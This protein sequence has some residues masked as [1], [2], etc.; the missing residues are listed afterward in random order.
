MKCFLNIFTRLLI[1]FI[2]SSCGKAEHKNGIWRATVKTESGVEVPFNFILSGSAGKKQLYIINGDERFKVNV[3][4]KDNDSL[5][6]QIPMFDC[7]IKAKIGNGT[8]TGQ[9]IKHLAAKDIIMEFNAKQ[10]VS[11]RFLKTPVKPKYNSTGRWSAPF[12]NQEGKTNILIG[13]FKQ[14]ANRLTGTFLSTTGDYRFLEGTISDDKLFLSSFN[15]SDIYLFTATLKSDSTIADGKFYSGYS[16]IKTWTAKKDEKAMLPDADSLIAL[17]PGYKNI[18]FSFQGLDSK[19]VSLSDSK[20]RKKVVV[21]QFLGSWCPNCMDETAYLVPFYKEFRT[22]GVE[23][24]G[25]AYERTKDFEKS[26]KSLQNLKDRFGIKYDL[27][28]TGYTDNAAE[29]IKSMPML[30]K[31]M[32]FPTTIILDKKGN[33]R[34]I[35]TGFSGPGTGDHYTEF[36]S[37]FEK[38]IGDLLAEK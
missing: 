15:G 19:N 20:F 10:D 18:D 28:I 9:S 1:L 24:V 33:V 8:L 35:H 38:F 6:I 2:I 3:I 21:V 27:L 30:N 13:E 23:I 5:F 4:E 12:V 14:D 36:K 11:W 37:E 29:V 7:E 16:A 22:R 26:K 31:F 34:K 25:L 17:N 32:G